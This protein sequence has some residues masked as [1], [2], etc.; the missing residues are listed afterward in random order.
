M[1]RPKQKAPCEASGKAPPQ[2]RLSREDKGK[3]SI[4]FGSIAEA[5]SHEARVE[6]LPLPNLG[7]VTSRANLILT[8][9][10]IDGVANTGQYLRIR[11]EFPAARLKLK[12]LAMLTTFAT[13]W[14]TKHHGVLRS[15]LLKR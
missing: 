14:Q 9:E 10:V 5:I 11:A 12:H 4:P 1:W 8:S 6:T 3:L 15:Q 13:R 7:A 2:C